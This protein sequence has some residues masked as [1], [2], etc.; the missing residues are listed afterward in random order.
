MGKDELDFSG[1][2]ASPDSQ[3]RKDLYGGEKPLR[4]REAINWIDASSP[5]YLGFGCLAASD[6]TLHLFEDETNPP[7]D[8]PLLQHV[9]LSTRKS[10]AWNPEYWF[11]QAGDHHYRMALFP[12]AGG[13]RSSYR[14]GLA[15][16]YPLAAF[17]GGVQVES[18]RQSLP[19]SAQFVSIEPPNLVVTALKV[20]EDDDSLV[21]RCYEAEGFET[22]A[23]IRFSRSIRQAWRTNL[24]EEEP[25]TLPVSPDGTLE[26]S[27][28]AWEIV[29]LK[30]AV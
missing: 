8:Y 15:F 10:M 5:E 14:E 23:R 18:G 3:F 24:I 16:N 9:L 1:L 11:T 28:K 12:H 2:P 4:F 30:V 7:L 17:V 20:C 6:C 21:S 26:F 19:R 13:W 22:R 25:E 27:V 29:T